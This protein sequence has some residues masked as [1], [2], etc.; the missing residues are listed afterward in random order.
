MYKLK[1]CSDGSIERFKARLVAK[2]FQQQDGLDYKE[3]FSPV[4]KPA[5]IRVVLAL[6]IHFNWPLRQLDVSNAFLHGTLEE[7]VYMEQPTG[8]VN[9][10][11]LEY[12]CKLK[13]AIYGLKQ[14]PRAWFNRL[15]HSLLCLGFTESY[16]DYSLF[17]YDKSGIKIFILIYLDNII[18]TGTSLQFILH[19]I[20]CLKGDFAMKDLGSLHFF[21]GI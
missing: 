21:L 15:T 14:A 19:L 20:N 17:I 11:F 4:I 5:T 10:A 2:G 13:K 1:H 9:S 16:V 6:A 3:T 18:V 12:V 7:E 8:F